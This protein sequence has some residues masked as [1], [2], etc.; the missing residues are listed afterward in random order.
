[1]LRFK[2]LGDKII[3][4]LLHGLD[5]P[6]DGAIGRDHHDG[7]IGGSRAHRLEHRQPVHIGHLDVEE[8]DLRPF[9]LQ[10]R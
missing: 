10:Q 6:F 2:G 9:F 5:G 3:G 1:V 8:N 7:D 4:A